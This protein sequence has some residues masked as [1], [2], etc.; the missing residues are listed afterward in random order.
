MATAISDEELA[1]RLQAEEMHA[2]GPPS[3][4][5]SSQPP[6]RGIV[7]A[8]PIEPGQPVQPVAVGVPVFGLALGDALDESTFRLYASLRLT[9]LV[10][11]MAFV[12]AVSALPGHPPGHDRLPRS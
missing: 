6:P 3:A 8:P 7:V 2:A 10:R 11:V 5:S 1:R 9:H 12:D 4:R